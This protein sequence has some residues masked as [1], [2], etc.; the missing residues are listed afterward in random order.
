MSKLKANSNRLTVDQWLRRQLGSRALNRRSV[1]G[2]LGSLG[3][4]GLVGCGGGGGDDSPPDSPPPSAPPPD[5]PPQLSCVL[6]P[7]ENLGPFSLY[8]DI[9]DAMGAFTRDDI[10]DDRTGAPMRLKLTILN[11]N[12]DCAPITD[13]HAY[14]WH[15]DK[16]GYYSGYEYPDGVDTTGEIFLRGVQTTDSNGEVNFISIYPGWYDA[17]STH[18][19]VRI[20]MGLALEAQTQLAF[21]ADVTEEVYALE[22]YTKGQNSMTHEMDQHFSDGVENQTFTVTRDAEGVY[23][24]SIVI[25]IDI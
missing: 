25:G 10:T 23:D 16:D 7:R 5:A 9:S 13:V 12:N 6:T 22:D 24:A 1:L 17:R 14:V 18:V 2:G 19:H 20:Y 4:L 11:V 15:C 21:P 8:T 3:G